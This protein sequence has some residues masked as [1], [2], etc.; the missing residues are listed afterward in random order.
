MKNRKH[1][2]IISFL[3]FLQHICHTRFCV[4]WRIFQTYLFQRILKMEKTVLKWLKV[5]K[6][7]QGNI[8][9]IVTCMWHK[10]EDFQKFRR[11]VKK[12]WLKPWLWWHWII[13]VGSPNQEQ[14]VSTPESSCAFLVRLILV[15][16][17]IV[18]GCPFGSWILLVERKAFT[19]SNWLCKTRW[20]I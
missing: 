15:H 5:E 2:F 7:K 10:R 6:R 4:I 3:L 16:V 13:D 8:H 9:V 12:V 1:T 11:V 17:T 19:I 14:G 18:N 20:F